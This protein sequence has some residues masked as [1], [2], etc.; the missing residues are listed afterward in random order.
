MDKENFLLVSSKIIPPVF[1]GVITAKDLL[2]NGQAKNVSE[3]VKMVG[4]SR[5]AFYKYRDYVF[6]PESANKKNITLSASLSDKAGV[7][8]NLSKILSE[9]GANIV[10]VNQGAPTGG[11]APVTITVCT[12]NCIISL[13]ELIKELKN[14]DGIISVKTI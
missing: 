6:K 4:I 5:S 9:N 7:F 12:D 13:D 1:K 11:F 8:S 10:T 14:A 2:S 3:A